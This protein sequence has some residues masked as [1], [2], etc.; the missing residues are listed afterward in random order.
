SANILKGKTVTCVSAIKDDVIN[1]GANYVDQPVV[2]HENIIT[3]RV[4]ADLPYF[5]Q[6]V[7]KALKS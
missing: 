5:C 2:R 7:I 1:A 6:E 3:S 4:P